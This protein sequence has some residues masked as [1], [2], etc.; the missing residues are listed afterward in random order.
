[1]YVPLNEFGDIDTAALSIE[2]VARSTLSGEQA[3]SAMT[4]I[5]IAAE[6]T[7]S[8]V[9]QYRSDLLLIPEQR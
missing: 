1:M 4:R 2:S 5:A 7:Y 6:L 9:W 3:S 8:E